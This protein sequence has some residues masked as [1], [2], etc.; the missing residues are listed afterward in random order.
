MEAQ[1][2]SKELYDMYRQVIALHN[3]EDPIVV[4]G[5]FWNYA[6]NNKSRWLEKEIEEARLIFDSI[7]D[8]F[9]IELADPEYYVRVKG[10][11]DYHRQNNFLKF[12][13]EDDI[14][15]LSDFEEEEG[16]CKTTFTISWLEGNWDFY[17]AY[18]DAGLL[19]FY[20]AWKPVDFIK[21]L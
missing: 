1:I 3:G 9:D 4:A 12:F 17:V 14:F 18:K 11:S 20:D 21:S 13:E 15:G 16:Y 6:L 19:E 5:F 7:I 10:F 8:K 2:Q